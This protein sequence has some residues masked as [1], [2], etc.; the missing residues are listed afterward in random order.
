[1]GIPYGHYLLHIVS[2]QVLFPKLMQA[3]G[4]YHNL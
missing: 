1:M 4:Y 3:A 2:H